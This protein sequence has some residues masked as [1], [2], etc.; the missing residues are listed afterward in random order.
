MKQKVPII[1]FL[2][3][4]FLLAG[5]QKN[6]SPGVNKESKKKISIV[7]TLFPLYDFARIICG[8]KAEIKLL[9][10]PGVEAHSYEPK[11][12][13]LIAISKADIFIYTNAVMEPW[14]TTLLK[15]VASPALRIVDASEGAA[16]R[17]AGVA[18]SH[19]E[20]GH[21][22]VGAMDPHLW[23]D[24]SN[25]RI[26]VDNVTNG[27]ISKDQ[28]NKEFYLANAQKYKEDLQKLDNDFKLGLTGCIKNTFLHG[29]HY[30][31]GYL[32]A[33]YGLTYRSAQAVNPD[34]EPTP[35]TIAQLLK[36]VKT[37]GIEYVYSEELVSP[38]ISEML[39]RETGVK[40]LTLHG[41][42][43]I[44]KDD[45]AGGTSFVNLMRENLKNLKTGLQCR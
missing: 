22:H 29:G 33:R 26:M 36:L 2:M 4:L 24:F 18:D 25:A 21:D 32:A 17:K 11:P 41:A 3:V 40:I 8:D 16:L 19:E 1:V 20:K 23:L 42:H 28:A 39:A 13:D 7:T 38:R 37:S 31:F 30:A 45:L 5:C 14:A 27:V 43:N 6:E 9:L 12:A 35:A 44:S 15:G 34:A 10:P